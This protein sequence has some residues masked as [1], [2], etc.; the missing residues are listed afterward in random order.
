MKNQ[1]KFFV[2]NVYSSRWEN[3]FKNLK[4]EGDI[5]KNL[6]GEIESNFT[7]D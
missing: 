4:L 1:D 5:Y 6:G 3:M 7:Q 2:D